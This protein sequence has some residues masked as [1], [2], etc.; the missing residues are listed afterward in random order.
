MQV[1]LYSELNF[2]ERKA[3]RREYYERFVKGWKQRACGACSGSGRYDNHGAP[4]CGACDGTGK[5]TYKPVSIEETAKAVHTYYNGRDFY[6]CIGVAKNKIV[7]YCKKQP[8]KYIL[9]QKEFD[10]YK[11]E[12]I[13][14]GEIVCG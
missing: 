11:I 5:E 3:R 8:P 12:F 1:R 2:A 7:V 6:N 4:P 13:V 10:G 14:I 9:K